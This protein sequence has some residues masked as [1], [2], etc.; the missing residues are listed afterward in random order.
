MFSSF[1]S[2]IFPDYCFVCK[3]KLFSTEYILCRACADTLK[4]VK[5]PR[6]RRCGLPQ[7]KIH[8]HRCRKLKPVFSEAYQIFE[9]NESL[10]V[11]IHLWKYE[12]QIRMTDFFV[13]LLLELT[14][15][16]FFEEVDLL[17][18]VPHRHIIYK[19]YNQSQVLARS[20]AA[21]LGCSV[22]PEEY[23]YKRKQTPSQTQFHTFRERKKNTEECFRAENPLFFERRKILIVD[24]VMTSGNTLNELARVLKPFKP[25]FIKVLTVALAPGM[26]YLST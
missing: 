3:R 20:L 7:K 1:A 13:R 6:C 16:A 19:G 2:F 15:P 21:Q 9:F 26:D 14:P 18:W 4:P 5:Q 10:R 17:A 8:C 24:D 23:L 12:E 25:A 22:C 11:L